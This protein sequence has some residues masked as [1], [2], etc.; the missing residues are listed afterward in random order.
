[1][2]RKEGKKSL[3]LTEK[4]EEAICSKGNGEQRKIKLE[5]MDW[6]TSVGFECLGEDSDL[7]GNGESF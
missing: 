6:F 2:K 4:S 1:M 5:S 3:E 7:M